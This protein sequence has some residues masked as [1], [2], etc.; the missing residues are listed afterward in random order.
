M[1]QDILI[2]HD[3]S[4]AQEL[5]KKLRESQTFELILVSSDSKKASSA[6]KKSFF[7]ELKSS[8]AYIEDREH[9]VEYIHNWQSI[10][11]IDIFLHPVPHTVYG[12]IESSLGAAKR[13]KAKIV[14]LLSKENMDVVE[15]FFHTIFE[16]ATFV[17]SFSTQSDTE[18]LHEKKDVVLSSGN[19]SDSVRY[20]FFFETAKEMMHLGL[21]DKAIEF[22]DKTR[23]FATT[24][25]KDEKVAIVEYNIGLCHKQNQN[26]TDAI[27][28]AQSADRHY[29]RAKNQ[30]G[31]LKCY[32]LLALCY[33]ESGAYSS[34]IE[35]YNLA[36]RIYKDMGYDQMKAEISLLSAKIHYKVGEYN[37][38]LDEYR[39]L[40][41]QFAEGSRERAGIYSD[42]AS[43][44]RSKKE[45]GQ[46]LKSQFKATEIYTALKL[47]EERAESMMKSAY[48]YTET[49][50][51]DRA[52]RCKG[53]AV[54]LLKR[55]GM[56][57]KAKSFV[58]SLQQYS[59][60]HR[61]IRAYMENVMIG[62]D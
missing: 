12:I 28:W 44:Y 2:P 18:F 61:H 25:Q 55:L 38:A 50:K 37:R 46:A 47:H 26:H 51:M 53:E 11:F 4:V 13:E 45:Y 9:F 8:N 59:T 20:D 54:K 62:G 58:Q 52:E 39:K 16:N 27:H 41:T 10:I 32:E 42:I 49:G 60:K 36:S 30:Q 40:E 17:H 15:N 22:W 33:Y 24:M 34:A 57:E 1:L 48:I 3:Y 21:Y 29:K 43:I 7:S 19:L 5:I 56:D 6:L 35:H 14:V 31:Q 23:E